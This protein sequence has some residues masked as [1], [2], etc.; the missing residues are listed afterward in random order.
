MRRP[1]AC[2]P[3]VRPHRGRCRGPCTDSRTVS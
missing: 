1:S 3:A 2:D